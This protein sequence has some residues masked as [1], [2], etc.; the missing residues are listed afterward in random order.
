MSNKTEPIAIISMACRFPKLDNVQQLWD[1][2]VNRFN[3][4]DTVPPERWDGD[5][6]YSTNEASK[7]K[8]YVRRGGFVNQD[9]RTFDASFFGI[10]PRE[11]ENMDPQQRLILEVVWEAFENCGL[12]LPDY[13]GQN[14]GVYVGGF[15]LD[16][17]ITQMGL[18]N[19]SSINQHSAAGMMMTM[20]SNRVSHTFDFRGPSLSIDTACSSSLV[21][22][23][24][25]CQDIWRNACEMAIVGGT[26]VMMRPEYPI[27][28]SKGYFLARD[29]ESKS[30]DVRGDGYGRGE[31][32]GVLLLKP[33]ERALADGDRIL[34]LVKGTGTNQ[35]GRTPGISMP[36]GESQ[37]QLIEEV[38][39]KY[40]FEPNSV[41][42]VECHGTGT[43]IGDPTECKAIG[44]T[45]GKNRHDNPVVI[46]SVK[47]NIGHLE[48]AA[49][50]AGVIKAVLTLMHRT[51]TPLANLET[52]RDDISF[53]DLGI[54]LSDELIP[55][56][57]EGQPVRVA[58]N[59]FG[60]GGSN[61]HVLLESPA[62]SPGVSYKSLS[63]GSASLN[64][65]P[66]EPLKKESE[67][68]Y[69]LPVSGRSNEALSENAC[70][71]ARHI[72]ASKDS[73]SNIIYS[74]SQRRAHHNHRAVAMGRERS[75]VISSL[76]SIAE[77]QE[78]EMVVRDVQPFQGERKPVFVF[79]GM[80]PQWWYMGQ[81]LFQ[82]Q[83]LYKQIVVEADDIFQRIA[84]F[85][86]LDEMLKREDQSEIQKTIYAQ[87]AN[88][89][90]QIGIFELMRESG[91]EPGLVVGHSVGELGSAYAAGV[92]SLEDALLVSYHRSQ[93]QAETAGEGGMLAIGLSK[94]DA[95]KRISNCRKLVSLAAVN[96]PSSVTLAG[97]IKS[98]SRIEKEL[99]S[100]GVFAKMLEVEIPY[101]SPMMD[102]LMPRLQKALQGVET[103]KPKIPL[104]S[105][106]TGSLVTE[107][108]FG[109]NYWPLN[110]RNPVE[111]EAA[112][113]SILDLGYNTFVEIGPHPVLSASLRDCIRVAGKDCRLI[114]TLRRNLPNE[115]LNVHRAI[116]GIFAAGCDF[117]WKPFSSGN[118]LVSLPNYQWQRERYWI[119]NDRAAQDRINPIIDPILGTQEALAS[120]V[121]RNDFDHESVHYLRDHV[122]SGLPILPAAGY[123]ESLLE[124]AAI[125]F[126]EA[127]GLVVR[128]LEIK[129][130]LILAPDRGIDFTTT[131]DPRSHSTI[132]RS[133]ENGR[134][135]A[136]NIHVTAKVAE[137]KRAAPVN[138]NLSEFKSEDD[139]SDDI[140]RFYDDLARIGLMYGPSFQTV[141]ELYFH[142]E[143]NSVLA[144]IEI[145]SKLKAN[146][147]KY[148]LH[149]TLLDGCFQTL[150]AMLRDSE[151]T[152]LP[153][154]IGE[155]CYYSDE[156]PSALW[157]VG[158]LVD[159]NSRQLTCNL[160]LVDDDGHTIATI[161]GLKATAA[162][163]PERTDRWGDKVKLQTL[164]YEWEH[165]ETL[166]EPK[167][168]GHW[169]S[170]GDSECADFVASRMESYGATIVG[171]ACYGDTFS[172][173]GHEST[174]RIDSLEDAKEV[175]NSA[176]Q[177]NGV[178]FFN[179][180]DQ[181]LRHDCPTAEKALNG[182]LTFVQAM[183]DIPPEKRPRIYVVTQTAFR[184]D[185]DDTEIDPGSA[186]LNG[187]A[188]VA[189]NELDGF[190]FSTV[191]L[192]SDL[193]DDDAL[194]ALVLELICDADEDEVAIRGHERFVSTLMENKL[195]T[196][197]IV[198]PTHLD[199]E[200]PI[201]IRPL[202]KDVENVGM[203]R[204]LAAPVAD[205]SP[206][207]I[208]LRV[209]SSLLPFNLI[210]DQSSDQIEQ[211]CIE[212]VGKIIKVGDDVKDLQVGSRVCGFAPA[213]LASHMCVEREN[214]HVV[215]IADE[216]NA[217]KLVGAIT[218]PV[219]ARRAVE[220]HELEKGDTALVYASPMGLAVANALSKRG[221]S[222]TLV[223]DSLEELDTETKEKYPCYLACPESIQ[224]AKLQQTSGNGFTGIVA[225]LSQWSRDFGFQSL[226]QYGWIIDTDAKITDVQ[227]PE[228]VGMISRTA[229]SS[230][231]RKPAKLT[232]VLRNV[233]ADIE[234]G[235]EVGDPT[236]DVSIADIAW[237]ALPLTETQSRIV[238]DYQTR[239]QDLPMVQPDALRFKSDATYLI[240]GGFGGFGRKTAEWLIENGAK[241][242]VL[243][244]RSGANTLEKKE[245]VK[246]LQSMGA[247]VKPVACDTSDLNAVQNLLAELKDSMPPIKG[248]F[249]SAAVILD[250]A[251]GESDLETFNKVMRAKATG[252]YNLHIATEKLELDHFVLYSSLANLIGNSRQGSYCASN[253]YLNGLAQMRHAQG[254]P[255]TA[256]NWGA[257]AEVGVVAQD[258]KLEQFLKAL[259]LRGITPEE[260]LNYLALA[261]SREVPQFGLVLIKSWA[262]WARFETIGSKLP[263]F[264][265]IIEGD[266]SPADSDARNQLVAELAPLSQGDRAELMAQLI[267][268]IVASV[269]KSETDSVQ[270]DR[271]INEL[272]ID[273]LM[274]T[275]IQILFES[276][277]GLSI[278][279]LELI[280]DT[281][282][283]SLAVSSLES[284]EAD[285]Q[286]AS[287]TEQPSE[288]SAEEPQQDQ[289]E[290]EATVN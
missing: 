245:I 184:I 166:A 208:V 193:D 91:V 38:C 155:L 85:S 117:D 271:P 224:E 20:L 106:V 21:A 76:L 200:H 11:A 140:V 249:H 142:P 19:R 183:L 75:E 17:M 164:N 97:H 151:S 141:K 153:T 32:A 244:G 203:V 10:S 222:V 190:K 147:S 280:G 119:E 252:A 283:R 133:Q 15:M 290:V 263:R 59:S 95:L 273:S 267:Q 174:I 172:Q 24:Y 13:A 178:V 9:V 84:G 265:S 204:V 177:L 128:D 137:V 115:S 3:A 46:G 181:D 108:S 241:S 26:N 96:G 202:R 65:H 134:L 23:H 45:Y 105:T 116:M 281:T 1:A 135:G 66:R 5:R 277:L 22:F 220:V 121:W 170:V 107:A 213:E 89:L 270:L 130:P 144:R 62:E 41:D 201:A 39:H 83:P 258:E 152:Y 189:A 211:P 132:I 93:L 161:R 100:E 287:D 143:Q 240:T 185:E 254:L 173:S 236:L 225:G 145:D 214:F 242:L 57:K 113:S 122:V 196:S 43:G 146:L 272:G 163:K 29:G 243:T 192:P 256:V 264:Q 111:F 110:I 52:P 138:V 47:S 156:P 109:A 285:F 103:N 150:M 28:M 49:G 40:Q 269:L 223:T 42:Y 90:I 261:L 34:S 235:I 129:A 210:L 35:D 82:S 77:G 54:R 88:L 2:L 217:T 120:A 68:P 250:Q 104:Y 127:K 99:T 74:A 114:H 70:E 64:G 180:I 37:Q 14:V 56:G 154:H 186:A 139:S 25:A 191:D 284:I 168:L 230:V 228:N 262:D 207:E 259:G 247:A 219:C 131:Y 229:L 33:L 58:V 257:I 274:A 79:T 102:P 227:I 167:R 232:N 87:P 216:A 221:V 165:G 61:A 73:L 171:K 215:P 179:G 226:E 160:S 238:I 169:L 136:A 125:Q 157:C 126:P 7:G 123:L 149:P 31:G 12:I 266:L 198:Q 233:V 94:A 286:K 51:A 199:D 234:S 86:I 30:F 197:D 27:G 187:F 50:V 248:I 53:K 162:S 188:R 209:E 36:N 4:A 260:G 67:I 275:E 6:Y 218:L 176:G 124:V 60:Y 239:G 72:E 118:K 288:T 98:L 246:H 282:I 8:A 16:H 194:E 69:A 205:P 276:N 253:G 237:Q 206:N 18:G 112:I 182:L 148:K 81:Q 175:L 212:I 231:L 55:L 101:H 289:I 251:V 268:Q 195:L 71:L 159:K 78:S 255:A 278:S 92:L 158:K 279:V 80:G 44:A 63:N 48:A